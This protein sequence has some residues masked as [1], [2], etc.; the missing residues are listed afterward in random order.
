[1]SRLGVGGD[2]SKSEKIQTR[3]SGKTCFDRIDGHENGPG[4]EPD[5]EECEGHYSEEANEEVRV[6]TVG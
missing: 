1:M 2:V 5:R 4:D 6:K 3:G